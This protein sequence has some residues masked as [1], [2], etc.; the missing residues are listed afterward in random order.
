MA[1]IAIAVSYLFATC[2]LG[3]CRCMDLPHAFLIPQILVQYNN[4]GKCQTEYPP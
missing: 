3:V 2:L 1:L 4:G